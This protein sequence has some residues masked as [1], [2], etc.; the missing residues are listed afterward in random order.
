MMQVIAMKFHV[1]AY[2]VTA[3]AVRLVVCSAAWASES[4]NIVETSTKPFLDI[5]STASYV[6]EPSVQASEKQLSFKTLVH[7]SLFINDREAQKFEQVWNATLVKD[8]LGTPV[9]GMTTPDAASEDGSDRAA[10]LELAAREETYQ[11]MS[12]LFF[13]LKPMAFVREALEPLSRPLEVHR[14]RNGSMETGFF[15][16]PNR[17]VGDGSGERVLGFRLWVSP[18]HN[19]NAMV[20]I[21]SNLKISFLDGDVVEARLISGDGTRFFGVQRVGPESAMLVLGF[22][23]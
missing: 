17:P 14:N 4:P 2:V 21:G 20:D 16:G 11:F 8:R 5:S 12:R 18:S 3:L 7:K 13:S 15:V 10:R 22:G 19:I 1:G 6:A 23:F 9:G